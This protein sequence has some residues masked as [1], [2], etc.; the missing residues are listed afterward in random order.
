VSLY[1]ILG[2]S[3]KLE[4][5]KA[6]IQEI[7]S[8]E[9]D[10]TLLTER[11]AGTKKTRKKGKGSKRGAF[12]S[13]GTINYKIVNGKKVPDPYA[14]GSMSS[15]QINAREKIGTKMLNAVNRSAKDPKAAAL[16]TRLEKRLADMGLPADKPHLYSRIWADATGMAKNGATDWRIAPK[17]QGKGKGNKKASAQKKQPSSGNTPE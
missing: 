4:D 15:S 9:L 8:E 17:K 10:N 1:I 3:M 12:T 11:V 6:L 7:V 14:K 16:R 13:A 2:Q 5:F